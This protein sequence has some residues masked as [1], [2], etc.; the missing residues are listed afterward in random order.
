M[1]LSSLIA[2]NNELTLFGD[3]VNIAGITAD[4]RNV[5]SGFLFVAI[6]GTR[7]D[8][9]LYIEDAIKRGA[10]ALLIPDNTDTKSFSLQNF[11]KT[12]HIRKAVSSVAAKFYPRQPDLIAAVT[13]TS[14]KTSTA[15]F[16]R[17]M[18]ISLG[19]KSASVGTLGL[20]TEK[21]T[22]YGSLT[23]PD[24]LTLHQ[25]L[26]SSAREG[27]THLVLEASSHGLS[28]N[29]LDHVQIKIG[30]FTNFSRD[31]LDYHETMENYFEAKLKLFT[32]R[33]A[34]AGTAV[35]N[36]DIPEFERLFE[37]AK[38]RGLKVLDY[39]KKAKEIRLLKSEP[40]GKGQ[41][42]E[43][44]LHG[45]KES[46]LLPVVGSFQVSNSLL[47]LGIVLAGG[48]KE[49]KAL[50][51]LSYVTGVPGRLELAGYTKDNAAVFIDYSHK[52][53]ALENVLKALRPHVAAQEGS[54]LG[55]IFGCG[56]NRD[57]GKR[58][59]MGEI[60]QRLADWVIVTDDNPRHEEPA[61]IRK[62][63]L[64]NLKSGPELKEIGDRA[65]A[66][67]VGIGQLQKGD[68]LVIAGKGHESGQIVG[69]QVLPFDDAEMARKVLGL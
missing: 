5:K 55:V 24:A 33:L 26:D 61:M 25:I 56:G 47:A 54:K 50:D 20:V 6:P 44:E 52:P 30:G 67:E 17:E 42:I 10:A 45:K 15:Q 66:I 2:S 7:E 48:E 8:G 28:L 19:H 46:F 1:R 51:A 39:G 62:E 23:T 21:E 68:V 60:A 12:P 4:S 13:G 3:D 65:K 58:P 27:I 14:G 31:H 22:H 53:D 11:V 40:Q 35:L 59:I 38:E 9:R 32:E 41:L 37:K 29:R 36:A 57:K 43:I 49:A 34:P 18:W 64:A 69:D 16:V 63:I